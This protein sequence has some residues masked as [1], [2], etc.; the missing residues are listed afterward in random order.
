V[1]TFLLWVCKYPYLRVLLRWRASGPCKSLTVC[2]CGWTTRRCLDRRCS[3]RLGARCP[4]RRARRG[5]TT[6]G[7]T[8][9]PRGAP[10]ADD[11][12]CECRR[13]CR[14]RARGPRANRRNYSRPLPSTASNQIVLW[15]FSIHSGSRTSANTR[16]RTRR[17]GWSNDFRGCRAGSWCASGTAPWVPPA[18]SRTRRSGTRGPRSPP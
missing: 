1:T 8:W 10:P 14:W 5:R 11:L 13:A 17:L 16:R 12:A 6:R 15:I 18:G 2:W 4:S 9:G 7:R 3:R